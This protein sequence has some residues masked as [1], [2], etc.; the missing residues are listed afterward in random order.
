MIR[1]GL[2]TLFFLILLAGCAHAQPGETVQPNGAEIRE[3]VTILVSVDGFRP[4]YLNRGMTPNLSRLAKN[5]AFGPMRPAF[6]TKTFPNH[7]TLVTGKRPDN[8]GIVGNKMEDTARP[9]E[10]FRMSST[11]PFWWDQAE[12][13]WIT[14]EEQGI[15]SATMFWPGSEVEFDG[16][17]PSDW[18][19]FDQKLSND[20]RV[21]AVIDWMRRPVEIRPKL[22]TLY[23]DTVDTAGHFYGPGD[24]PKL[25][26]AIA[27]VDERIGDLMRA[28]NALDQPANFVVV[29][30]HGMTEL[31]PMRVIYLDR[32]LARD[33]YRLI[34]DGSYAG[35]QPL[36]DNIDAVRAAFV[37]PHEQMECWDREDIP[38]HFQFGKN[39]RVPSVFCLPEMGWVVYQDVPEWLTGVHGGH[40]YDHR[41]PDMTAFFLAS[42]PK[43][44]KAGQLPIFDNVHIYSLLAKLAGVEE[45]ESDGNGSPF[46]M[47]F[48]TQK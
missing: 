6:P 1:H 14:A 7:W 48:A 25:N 35:I 28:L 2:Q 24:G 5:G 41:H 44:K 8:H 42:G 21:R 47:L 27:E 9:D 15:R 33:Q 23:F 37:R 32:I 29:S 34:T 13:I 43:I 11:D 26:A 4:D 12:P 10:V 31:S 40:G 20:R 17:R 38:D 30:D 18:W 19:P 16:K 36:D 22:I 46:H 39:P 3:P 45:N